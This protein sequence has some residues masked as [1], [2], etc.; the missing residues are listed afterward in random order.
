M[1]VVFDHLDQEV[2][3]VSQAEEAEGK[4]RSQN[5]EDKL[6]HS[7]LASDKKTIE[8]AELI[9][10]A[11]NRSIGAF[12]PDMLFSQLVKNF[13]ITKQ[14]YGEKLLRL[15]AGYDPRYIEKNL[16][17]PEFRNELR[18]NIA[19]NIDE[20]KD[21]DL[22]TNDGIIS[23]KGVELSAMVLVKDLD[24]YIAKDKIGEKINKKSKH[25]GDKADTRP[26]HRGDRYKDLH[27][28]KSIHKAIKRGRQTIRREDL[29]TAEREGKGHISI[30]FA[31]DASASMKGNKIETCKK[32]GITLAHKAIDEKND[33]GLVVFGSDI[34]NAIPPTQDFTR[35]LRS[36]STIRAS[37]QTDFSAMIQHS[38]ELFPPGEDTKHLIILTDALPTVGKEPERDTLQAVSNARAAGITISIIGVQLD[39]AGEALAKDITRLGEGKFTLAKNL[40]DIGHIV[41]ED[42]YSV[43]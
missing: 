23:D 10:E 6:M 30:I 15:L 17:I 12:T 41:L 14:L 36:I 8:H 43:R 9:Q 7:V 40:D 19:K 26:Y 22:V 5:V 35:L 11:T 33:V 21:Q 13:Q 24:T 32:A 1:V 31:L 39:T 27:L 29:V 34:K 25:Y 16:N 42:Y 18:E 3:D 28:K 38:I 2:H 20:L 37:R 4:L